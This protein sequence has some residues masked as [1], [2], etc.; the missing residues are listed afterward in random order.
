MSLIA[1]NHKNETHRQK[2]I[3]LR[4]KKVTKFN[5]KLSQF[6]NKLRDRLVQ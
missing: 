3:V 6:N 2:C 1:Q 5:L 4:N